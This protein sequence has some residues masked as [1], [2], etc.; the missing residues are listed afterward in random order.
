MEDF[1]ITA[2]SNYSQT[3]NAIHQIFTISF[4]QQHVAG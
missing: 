1:I 3:Q 4:P 2:L